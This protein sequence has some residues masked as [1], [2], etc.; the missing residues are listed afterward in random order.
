M[1]PVYKC[2]EGEFVNLPVKRLTAW[3]RRD[4]VKT[5]RQADPCTRSETRNSQK[6]KLVNSPWL[7]CSSETSKFLPFLAK[8]GRKLR[9]RGKGSAAIKYHQIINIFF[10]ETIKTHKIGNSR[11]W[12]MKRWHSKSEKNDNSLLGNHSVALFLNLKLR[13]LS[14]FA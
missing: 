7:I 5:G 6:Q 10:T 9:N 13:A 12:V 11:W 3:L 8:F 1:G 14:N 4:L 2:R